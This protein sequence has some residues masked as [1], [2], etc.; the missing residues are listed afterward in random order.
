MTQGGHDGLQTRLQG[1][2]K[3]Y[4][5]HQ[6]R[7]KNALYS[8]ALQAEQLKKPGR[9]ALRYSLEQVRRCGLHLGVQKAEQQRQIARRRMNLRKKTGTLF[10]AEP[11]GLGTER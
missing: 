5:G 1:T 8:K 10:G 9:S 6:P 3:D 2:Q 11:R 4:K 7:I